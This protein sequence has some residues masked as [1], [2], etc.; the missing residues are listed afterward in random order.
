MP[1]VPPKW[2]KVLGMGRQAHLKK[3]N[4]DAHAHQFFGNGQPSNGILYCQA[5]PRATHQNDSTQGGS[6]QTVSHRA[7]NIRVVTISSLFRAA[8]F[9]IRRGDHSRSQPK[10]TISP[11]SNQPRLTIVLPLAQ[12]TTRRQAKQSQELTRKTLDF[13]NTPLTINTMSCDLIFLVLGRFATQSPFCREAST[14]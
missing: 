7:E 1:W 6:D 3:S 14:R 10:H 11:E 5:N 12:A 4:W 13:M 9:Q 2:C 8:R